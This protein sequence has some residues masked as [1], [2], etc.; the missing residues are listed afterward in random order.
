MYFC[1][2]RA[3]PSPLSLLLSSATN[4]KWH[5]QSRRTAGAVVAR[6]AEVTDGFFLSDNKHNLLVLRPLSHSAGRLMQPR[7]P[8]PFSAT[9]WFFTSSSIRATKD[10]LLSL[11][12]LVSLPFFL[13]VCPRCLIS[14]VG[15]GTN[16]VNNN[17]II[18]PMFSQYKSN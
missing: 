12:S 13:A 5:T 3:G 11:S 1:K 15:D 18:P 9:I 2:D 6:S 14:L 10:D 17:H 4:L 16:A 8:L 7:R